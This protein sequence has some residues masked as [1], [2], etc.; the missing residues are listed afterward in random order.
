MTQSVL[1][2]STPGSASYTQ[3]DNPLFT[4]H[5]RT[6]DSDMDELLE[7]GKYIVTAIKIGENDNLQAVCTL[8]SDIYYYLTGTTPVT[9]ELSGVLYFPGCD[10]QDASTFVSAIKNTWDTYRV[11]KYK[12]PIR[13]LLDEVGYWFYLQS[14]QW[15]PV[16]ASSELTTFSLRGIGERK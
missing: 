12:K 1:L 9:M 4:L 10:G 5:V 16:S 14:A 7:K 2:K 13:L 3:A 6:G 11:S 15:N 8:G